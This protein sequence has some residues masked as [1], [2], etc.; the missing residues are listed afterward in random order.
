MIPIDTLFM[1]IILFIKNL[2][3][4]VVW[5]PVVWMLIAMA[6]VEVH[7][8][9]ILSSFICGDVT[10]KQNKKN[11]SVEWSHLTS[12]QSKCYSFTDIRTRFAEKR[13]G[14]SF[15][16]FHLSRSMTFLYLM[17]ASLCSCFTL[18]WLVWMM[19]NI[20]FNRLNNHW[21]SQLALLHK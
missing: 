19:Y 13:T 7:A 11:Q 4:G 6:L 15:L 8:P 12:D 14:T 18:F 21:Y 17:Q 5:K 2:F 3:H 16:L 10:K 9:W 20:S 1:L